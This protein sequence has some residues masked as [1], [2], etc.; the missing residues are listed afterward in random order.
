MTNFITENPY[1]VIFAG[2]VVWFLIKSRIIITALDLAKLKTK[3]ID[4]LKKD[5][6]FVTPQELSDASGK[7]KKDAEDRFLTLAAFNEF[8]TGIDNQFKSVF[9]RFDEGTAQF[10]AIFKGID[11]IKNYLMK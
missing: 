1:W 9:K 11:D 2:M 6:V 3:I 8:K 4:E 5:K 10:K 7:I